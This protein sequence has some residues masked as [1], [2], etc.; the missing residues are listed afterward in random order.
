MRIRLEGFSIVTTTISARVRRDLFERNFYS[1][2]HTRR[3]S[4]TIVVV[5][6]KSWSW[7]C[8]HCNRKLATSGDTM[9]AG[10][11]D[12][13]PLAVRSP[14]LAPFVS[15]APRL[16]RDP[17]PLLL[18]GNLMLFSTCFPPTLCLDSEVRGLH[19]DRE[20]ECRIDADAARRRIPLCKRKTN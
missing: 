13:P 7:P 11:C 5:L 9:G 14:L 3:K 10:L 2:V 4:T 1:I 18:L 8:P 15:S 12:P 19:I 16:L 17:S 20:Q 6:P